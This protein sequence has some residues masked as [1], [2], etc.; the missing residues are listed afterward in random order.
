[1]NIQLG[2]KYTGPKVI[3]G[4]ICRQRC[5]QERRIAV[6]PAA[7]DIVKPVLN[8]TCIKVE[9]FYSTEHQNFKYLYEK[10]L[11]C[12]GEKFWSLDVPL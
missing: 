3:R 8:R 9:H 2:K 4:W 10:E 1:M 6:S 11:P 5:L 12:N 7:T